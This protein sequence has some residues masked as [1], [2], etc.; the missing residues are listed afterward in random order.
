MLSDRPHRVRSEEGREH[1]GSSGDSLIGDAG[2]AVDGRQEAALGVQ[3]RKDDCGDAEQHD[4]A[5]DK[6]VDRG[7]HVAACNDVDSGQDCHDDD[8][9]CV[10]D[11]K[12]HSEQTGKTVVERCRVRDEEDE[13]D[14]GCRDLQ[15][16]ASEPGL[17]ELGHGGGVQ[18]LRHDPCPASQ[19]DPCHQ[20]AD[21]GV[22]DSCPGRR[23]A[24]LPSEL[25]CVTDEDNCGKIGGS[26]CESCEPGSD[27]P[28]AEDK[29]VNIRGMPSAVHADP[30]HNRKE[31]RQHHNFNSHNLPPVI[32]YFFRFSTCAL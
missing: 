27:R 26:V 32:L 6:V 10:V 24:V 20:G 29:P 18:M 17:K 14:H 31:H 2:E 12:S 15:R 1:T 28:A 5:L 4:N 16:R 7:G 9:D 23:D 30:Y 8:T 21:D 22:S 11:V 19:D 25:T 13:G 3:H